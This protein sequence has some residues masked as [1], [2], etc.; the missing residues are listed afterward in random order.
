MLLPNMRRA[1]ATSAPAF[2]GRRFPTGILADALLADQ[3]RAPQT[4]D[5]ALPAFS[6]TF[7]AGGRATLPL[8]ISENNKGLRYHQIM[9]T[10]GG[11]TALTNI[12]AI[13]L[14][15]GGDVLFEPTLTQ[16][17]MINRFDGRAALTATGDTAV[18]DFERA[19]LTD[20][21][22]RWASALNVGVPTL[23][24][25]IGAPRMIGQSEAPIT[26][27]TLEV[28]FHSGLAG[29]AS[30]S[31]VAVV[32]DA[33]GA[34]GAFVVRRRRVS[35]TVIAGENWFQPYQFFTPNDF[36]LNRIFINA[37]ETNLTN[38]VID[39]DGRNIFR[40]GTAANRKINAEQGLRVAQT[41]WQ[42]Y[43]PTETGRH[44]YVRRLG[45]RIDLRGTWVTPGTYDVIIETLGRVAS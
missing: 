32:S 23:G 43:D 18:I 10:F 38:L 31:A 42:V 2:G 35:W 17:D 4:R 29:T 12:E 30:L 6:G 1:R 5:M 3:F 25:L 34:Q 8:P 33:N 7:T 21:G 41:N 16:L 27:A 13:R 20:G 36:W 11:T 9:L 15:L 37:A 22:A 44:E 45:K 39:E 28:Q 26:D 24:A 14:R 40:R 19:R